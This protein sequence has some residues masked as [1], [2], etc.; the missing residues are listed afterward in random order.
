MFPLPCLVF[1]LYF[2]SANPF[3]QNPKGKF[4]T[5]RWLQKDETTFYTDEMERVQQWQYY[6]S[7]Y[8]RIENTEGIP[9][10]RLQKVLLERNLPSDAKDSSDEGFSPKPLV[11]SENLIVRTCLN[12]YKM[13]FEQGTSDCAVY[14]TDS[15]REVE[16][17]GDEDAAQAM[18]SAELRGEKIKER[19][20]INNQWMKGHSHDEVQR[21]KD[22][23][24]R[25]MD[26]VVGGVDGGEGQGQDVAMEG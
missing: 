25:W 21:S 18:F 4:A 3:F 9:R 13:V 6:I 26:G 5:T 24:Q 16:V 17:D 15:A 11:Y 14:S 1:F 12:S 10:S 8:I 23:F 7:S 20:L 19:L 2:T 22:D